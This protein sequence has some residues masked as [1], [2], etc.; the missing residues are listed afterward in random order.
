[1]HIVSDETEATADSPKVLNVFCPSGERIISGGAR[2]SGSGRVA[3]TGSVPFLSTGSSGWSGSGA[4]V[5][6]T[7]DPDDPD[8]RVTTGQTGDFSWALQVFAVCGKIG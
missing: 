3:L 5:S 6:V 8:K 1:M 4:E 7:T 2:V